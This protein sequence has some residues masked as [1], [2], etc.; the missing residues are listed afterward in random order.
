MT[1]TFLSFPSRGSPCHSGLVLL[2]KTSNRDQLCGPR[3]SN[4]T[5]ELAVV[6]HE[7]FDGAAL[8]KLGCPDHPVPDAQRRRLRRGLDCDHQEQRDGIMSHSYNEVS[9]PIITWGT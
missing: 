1:G 5:G 7:E 6:A 4:F 8:K 3:E 2:F 9:T